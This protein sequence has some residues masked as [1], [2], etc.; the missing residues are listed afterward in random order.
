MLNL[1]VLSP[2][3]QIDLG[4]FMHI[5][6]IEKLNNRIFDY[7]TDSYASSRRFHCQVGIDHCKLNK[8]SQSKS[9]HFAK[10]SI[11]L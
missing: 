1:W 3:I 4:S 8:V 7:A 6:M 2:I 10:K 9:D 11:C 5:I